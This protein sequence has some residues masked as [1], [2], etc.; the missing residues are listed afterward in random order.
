MRRLYLIS[1]VSVYKTKMFQE[2]CMQSPDTQSR[3]DP[4]IIFDIK[5]IV[6]LNY[7]LIKN[8]LIASLNKLKCM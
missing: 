1:G 3:I 2:I 5:I 7:P 6:L 8:V 4:L